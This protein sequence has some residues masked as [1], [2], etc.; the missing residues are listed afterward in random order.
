MTSPPSNSALPNGV[1]FDKGVIRR[2]YERRMRLALNLPPTVLQTEAANA[3]ARFK[4]LTSNL[5][6]TEQTFNILKLRTPVFAAPL[7]ADA[8]PL[9]KGRYLRRWARRLRDFGFSPEDAIVIAYG[10]FGVSPDRTSVG[11]DVIVTT[12]IKMSA[13]YGNNFDVIQ[14]RFSDLVTNLSPA[15]AALRLPQVKTTVYVLMK[16]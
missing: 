10:S 2:V 8:K 4:A 9:L 15:Y 13:R 6:I 11:V 1:L 7:L 16:F 5:F 14:S 12:D 3:Y